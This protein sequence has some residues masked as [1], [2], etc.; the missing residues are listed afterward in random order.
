[1]DSKW[2]FQLVKWIYEWFR[3]VARLFGFTFFEILVSWSEEQS[4]LMRHTDIPILAQDF[5]IL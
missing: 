3:N 1:M 4:L 2:N 5:K